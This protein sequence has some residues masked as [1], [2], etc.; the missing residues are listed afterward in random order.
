VTL[1]LLIGALALLPACVPAGLVNAHPR[2]SPEEGARTAFAAAQQAV[3]LEPG[4][5]PQP[6]PAIRP[7]EEREARDAREPE[8]V[9]SAS[10]APARPE[11]DI[12][13]RMRRQFTIP[14]PPLARIQH[15]ADWFRRNPDYFD[16]VAERSRDYLPYIV[17]EAE[18]RGIPVE[19]ALLPVIESA[20]QPFA[21]SPARAS[22]LWQFIPSTARLYGLRINWWY[23]G[24]RD[25]VAS[26]SAAFEYL[27]KLHR[28]FGEDWLLAVAAYNWGE[29]NLR[30]AIARNRKRGKPIDFWSLKVPSETRTYV[31]RWLAVCDIVAQPDHYGMT[32]RRVPDEVTFRVVEVDGQIDLARAAELANISL[33]RLY[34]LNAGYRRW[35]TEPKGPQR[36]LVPAPSAEAFATKVAL[37]SPERRSD[38]GHHVVRA[39][40]TLSEIAVRYGTSVASLTRENRLKGSLIRVGD[41]LLIPGKPAEP[42]S[43][44]SGSE[45]GRG[46]AS[47]GGRI[48][49]HES[50]SRHRVRKGESLWLIAHRYGV[51]VANLVAWNRLDPEAWLMPG[52]TLQ[53]R[54]STSESMTIATRD[55]VTGRYV[56][57][58]GDNLWLIARRHGVS[59]ADL[60]TWNALSPD[61]WLMPGQVLA[62]SGSADRT[63]PAPST[64]SRSPGSRNQYVVRDGDN[65]WVIARR[66]GVSVEDLRAWNDLD[67]DDWLRPGQILKLDG[68][69]PPSV[70]T[71]APGSTYRSYVVRTGDSLWLI[72]RRIG[73]SVDNLRAWNGLE[74]AEWLMPGQ[75][76]LLRDSSGAPASALS[77]GG[78]DDEHRYVVR[79]GDSLWLI[80]RRHSISTEQLA[81]WNEL[82]I[83]GVLQ[84]GQTLQVAPPAPETGE[85]PSTNSL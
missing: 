15:Q 19:L 71:A 18:R 16:R 26:T 53:L 31:P 7:P 8:A 44:P 34:R 85:A 75:T 45:T 82:S 58:N 1:S 41:H 73:V 59:I 70:S 47:A 80:A 54:A 2:A 33:E 49:G 83:N 38:W 84:P 65:L 63:S 35:A 14:R 57:R 29:G 60:R 79:S 17:H 46:L 48:T 21:Y 10:P 9:A 50:A 62:L 55:E 13:E 52:Q 5:P 51:P 68:T 32:L 36:L 40:D 39:G 4:P 67:L 56:V 81:S 42:D 28:D 23:D 30:R 43:R 25:L 11:P 61:E 78:T 12:W 37:L 66:R 27:E 77:G 64:A 74:P 72:A 69:A 20:F 76:L 22:G 24:R 3:R 6:L